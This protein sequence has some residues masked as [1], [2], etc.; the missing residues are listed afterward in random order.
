MV[1]P[2]DTFLIRLDGEAIMDGSLSSEEEFDPPLT[3]PKTIDDPDD[4][5]PK[6]WV[7]ASEVTRLV[8]TASD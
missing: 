5:K 4:H 6:D 7:D 2:D 3:P 8:C 1:R